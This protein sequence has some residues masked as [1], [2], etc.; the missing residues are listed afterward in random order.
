V[1]NLSE[2]RPPIQ[3]ARRSVRGNY[4][5]TIQG[6]LNRLHKVKDTSYKDAWRK[7]GEVLGIFC[8][9]ARKFDRL[10]VAIDEESP[11]AAESLPDTLADLCVYAG[12]YLTW[13]A[14]A[15]PVVF[16]SNNP[17]IPFFRMF[18]RPGC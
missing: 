7:R 11:S 17:H 9:L 2:G 16:E 6:L 13:L 1:N 15:Q 3:P 14:E 10:I 12:K 4:S 5:D 18:R 8:N